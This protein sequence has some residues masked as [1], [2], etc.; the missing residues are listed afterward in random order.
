MSSR[1]RHIIIQTMKISTN[2]AKIAV[3]SL[4]VLALSTLT[5]QFP[6]L[7]AQEAALPGF[8]RITPGEITI[9]C[10]DEACAAVARG[11]AAFTQRNLHPL[12][13]NG[14]SCADCHMP[15]DSFQLSPATAKA[16]LDAL[17]AQRVYNKQADDPLFRPVDADDFRVSG[18]NATDYSNLV[19]NG[20]IRVTMPLPANVKLLDP[21]TEQP[22]AQDFVDLWRA[23]P[24]L[25]DVAITGP[26]GL[27]PIHPPGAPRP[28]PRH[29]G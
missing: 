15:S 8:T 12:G 24:P 20:L 6:A 22:M 23:V 17:L 10:D 19:E 11:R 5:A 26:D 28:H 16:R 27:L 7:H 2:T 14:R 3:P 25:L 18:E 9:D 29:G 4:W 1:K 13:G 21:I